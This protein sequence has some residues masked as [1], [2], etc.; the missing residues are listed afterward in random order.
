VYGR[1]KMAKYTNAD[2]L[3]RGAEESMMSK[4]AFQGH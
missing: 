3:K 4:N 2:I 1:H